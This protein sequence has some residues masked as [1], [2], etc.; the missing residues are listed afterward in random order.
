MS[1]FWTAFWILFIYIPLLVTWMLEPADV[2][3]RTDRFPEPTR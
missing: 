3:R 2:F 1:P